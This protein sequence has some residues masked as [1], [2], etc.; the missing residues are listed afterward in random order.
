MTA[1]GQ[2]AGATFAAG[3]A[4]SVNGATLIAGVVTSMATAD[5]EPLNSSGAMAGTQWG[6]G[7]VDNASGPILVASII[8][9]IAAELPRFKDSGGAAGTQWGAGF[10][11]T[12]ETGIA[13]PLIN[14][15]TTL[16]T[17]GVLAAIQAGNSQT[18][19]P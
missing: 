4:A 13:Q 7:F 15:L 16:V 11:G 8:A 10:M 5:L 2:G 3:F 12:V 19:P 14:L 17:P 6:A 9:K 1:A 18:T